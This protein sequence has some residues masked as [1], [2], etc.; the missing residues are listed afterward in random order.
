MAK[1][2]VV[3]SSPP[4]TKNW[5]GRCRMACGSLT[6]EVY[7]TNMAAQIVTWIGLTRGSKWSH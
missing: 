7:H 6:L 5:V 2:E 4:A 3:G 1:L